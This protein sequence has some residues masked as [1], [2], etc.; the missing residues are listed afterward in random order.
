GRPTSE[1]AH[2]PT[3]RS[4]PLCAMRAGCRA[5]SRT[6]PAATASELAVL[7]FRVRFDDVIS[8]T[9]FEHPGQHP[10]SA[11]VNRGGIIRL[12]GAYGKRDPTR[13]ARSERPGLSRLRRHDRQTRFVRADGLHPFDSRNI[14]ESADSRYSRS[15]RLA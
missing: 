3:H 7:S 10:R 8:S 11:D 1:V 4:P 5:K 15:S 6:S 9:P 2:V 14:G 12:T 13:A